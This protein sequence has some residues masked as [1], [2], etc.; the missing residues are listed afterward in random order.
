MKRRV[1]VRCCA[2]LLMVLGCNSQISKQ[3][4]ALLEQPN[5][6]FI[7][8]DDWGY[9]DLGC[10]GNTEVKT[11]NIDQLAKEGKRFTQFHNSSGVCS[12]SRAS[13]LTGHFP[14]RHNIHGT[15][16]NNVLNTERGMPNWLDEKTPFL[17]PRMMQNLGYIT[18]HFGKWDLGKLPDGD[19]ST[20]K[21]KDYGYDEASVWNGNGPI[22]KGEEDTLWVQNS[23]KLVID[24][25]IDF[26]L[27]KKNQKPLFIN[28][29]MKDPHRPLIPSDEQKK[30]YDGF[31][32]EKETYYAVL[33][34]A[35]KHIGRLMKVLEELHLRENTILIFSSD[36][37]PANYDVAKTA[38]STAGLRGR[39]LDTFQ[40]GIN[41]PFIISWPGHVKQGAVDSTSVLSGVD[42]LPTF[43]ELGGMEELP[44]AYQADG[45]SFASVFEN[46]T[47]NRTKPLFWDWRF[48]VPTEDQ[49]DTHW[50]AN[51]VRYG[52]WK[53]LVDEENK[54][55]ELYH[56]TEDR[57]EQHNLADK[58][59]YMTKKLSEKLQQWKET[60]PYYTQKVPL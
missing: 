58:N 28:L 2:L 22:W 11:P 7:Y 42:I 59:E 30:V 45:E 21:P 4:V 31:S 17:L 32:K 36:N 24:E 10:Y 39:M 40:G 53:L 47:F 44:E 55:Q 33:S 37:G 41:V 60:L 29:W 1:I 19:S 26:I 49:N 50:V 3:E 51:A 6:I 20:P 18:A 57:F 23:S 38:G 52:D 13:I 16:E 48:S 15:F 46:R 54:R 9:G 35:D 12:P 43:C 56:L 25:A 14:A 34:E 27:R 8:T 5:I